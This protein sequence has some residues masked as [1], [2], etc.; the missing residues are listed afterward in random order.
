MSEVK[1]ESGANE[2]EPQSL[3]KGSEGVQQVI[4]VQGLN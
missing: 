4:S 1:R 2:K 3:M